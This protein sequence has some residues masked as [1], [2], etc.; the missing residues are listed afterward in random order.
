MLG[1]VLSGVVY[2]LE[3]FLVSVEVDVAPGLPN[4]SVVG[5]PDAAV[6]ESKDRVR[7]A[8]KNAGFRFPVKKITVNLA[9]ADVKKEGSLF[10]LPMAVGILAA[11]GLI[12][13]PRDETAATDEFHSILDDYLM[14]GE[15]SPFAGRVSGS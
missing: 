10:D 12:T 2:G 3:A 8:I 14:V 6:K 13:S 5:L 15:Q 9:P 1:R 7:A 4:L 11:E